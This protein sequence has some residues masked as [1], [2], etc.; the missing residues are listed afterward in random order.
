MSFLRTVVICL[1]RKGYGNGFFDSNGH[2][3]A[4]FFFEGQHNFDHS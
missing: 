2:V 3:G 4:S 1:Q